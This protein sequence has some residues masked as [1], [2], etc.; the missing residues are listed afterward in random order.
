MS[1]EA[2]FSQLNL[3][4]TEI[5]LICSTAYKKITESIQTARQLTIEAGKAASN[6]ENE[7]Y[8]KNSDSI[9]EKSMKSLKK[10]HKIHQNALREI[11]K[12][13]GSTF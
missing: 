11:K 12:T 10:S 9:I 8:P 7:L 13:E 2:F 4:K 3:V 5:D 6:S 1:Y